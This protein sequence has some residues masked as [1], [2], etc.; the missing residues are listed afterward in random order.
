[1]IKNHSLLFLSFFSLIFADEKV[2]TDRTPMKTPEEIQL[3]I[4]KAQTDFE[5]AEIMF[6][7]WYTG[8][9]IT[10]SASMVPPKQVML[11]PYLYFTTNYAA[12]NAQRQSKG[13]PNSYVL[14]PLIVIQAGITNWMDVTTVP[15][16]YFKWS[17]GEYGQGFGDLPIQLGFPLLKETLY[18]PKM[19]LLIGETFPTGKYQH[20]N[21]NKLGLD[22]SGQGAFQT[23]IALN[24]T[25]VFWWFELHPIATRLGSNISIPNNKI[26]VH[27]FNAYG[28]GYGTNGKIKEGVTLNLDFGLEVS[29]NQKWVFATDIAYTYS[30]KSTFSGTAGELSPGLPAINGLPWSDSLSLAPAIEYN[31]SDSAG[32]IAGIWFPVTGRNSANFASLVLSY[33]IVI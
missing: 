30:A 11:Q 19:K 13:V 28:G 23:L 2:T 33:Y 17:Q 14:N 29:I 25:K 31:Q 3:E 12:F 22:I 7:P 10:G 9:L 15:G 24:M 16:G 27:G 32:F 6:N 1:M 18:I 21:P 4:N 8:P 5:V 26:N 20:L